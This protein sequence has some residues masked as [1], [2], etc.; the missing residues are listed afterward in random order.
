MKRFT[1]LRD[2]TADRCYPRRPKVDLTTLPTRDTVQ[3]TIYKLR[4]HEPWPARVAA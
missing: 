2:D 4:R 3:L 1:Y